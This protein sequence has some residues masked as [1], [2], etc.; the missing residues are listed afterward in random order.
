[1]KEI[2][3]AG[4]AELLDADMAPVLL[5][6]REAWEVEFARIEGAL[7]IPMA[8]IPARAGELDPAKPIVVMCH[9]GMRSRQVAQWLLGQGFADVSN[10]DGGIAAWSA[11]IDPSV[12]RY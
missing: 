6:V 10:F 11:H 3:A 9:H 1:V 4:L 8:Q 2:D 5:D 7:H 12:P